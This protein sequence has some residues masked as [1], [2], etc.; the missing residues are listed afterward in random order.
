MW[1]GINH[2]R[3]LEML[4]GYARS[5]STPAPEVAVAGTGVLLLLGGL[6][7]VLGAYPV[8]GVILLVIFLLGVSIKIHNFW[9]V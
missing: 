5:K 3:N 8:I 6:S 1:N 7:T 2:F 4:A 9:A